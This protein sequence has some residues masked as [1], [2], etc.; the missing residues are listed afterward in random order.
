[1]AIKNT[2]FEGKRTKIVIV[3]LMEKMILNIRIL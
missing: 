3:L 1:M 2:T